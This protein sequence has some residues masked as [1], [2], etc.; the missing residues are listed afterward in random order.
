MQSKGNA[1][2]CMAAKFIL[3]TSL[4]IIAAAAVNTTRAQP[5][6][7]PEIAT[8]QSTTLTFLF[9]RGTAAIL[10]FDSD[11]V[12]DTENDDITVRFVFTIPDASTQDYDDRMETTATG[13]LL[14]VTQNGHD[15]EFKA[16][17]GVSPSDFQEVYEARHSHDVEVKMYA[18][19]GVADSQPLSFTIRTSYDASA[20]FHSPAEYQSAQRWTLLEI[21]IYEG[22]TAEAE[23]NDILLGDY[24]AEANPLAGQP[25]RLDL[26]NALQVPWTAVTSTSMSWKLGTPDGTTVPHVKCRD[27]ARL[28]THEWPEAGAKD[29]TDF[30]M[31]PATSATK[32]SHTGVRF[33]TQ[34]DHENPA[35]EDED[36]LYEVRMFNT[37]TVRDVDGPN[38]STGCTGSAV[39]L[40]VRVKDVGPPA[41]PTGVTLELNAAKAIAVSWNSPAPNEFIQDGKRVAFPH[42]S[43][44]VSG[45]KVSYSPDGLTQNSNP[46]PNPATLLPATTGIE[47]L[48]GTPGTTYTFTMVLVNSEGNSEEVVKSITIPGKPDAPDPVTLEPDG[49]NAIDIS[50][51]EPNDQGAAITGYKIQYLKPDSTEW[52]DWPHTG[53]NATAR[54]TGLKPNSTYHV[55][56]KAVN[57]EG[58][59]AWSPDKET[60]TSGITVSLSADESTVVK[61][62]TD[63]TV[64]VTLDEAVEITAS[65]KYEWT[66]GFGT[67]ETVQTDSGSQMSWT[68]QSAVDSD[69]TATADTGTLTV[70]VEDSD[71]YITGTSDSVTI[72]LAIGNRAPVIRAPASTT[73]HHLFP[74]GTKAKL[75][76]AGTPATDRNG[77][78]ISYSFTFAR[79]GET[80][81]LSPADT[82]LSIERDGDDF[83]ISALG[84]ATPAQYAALHGAKYTAVTLDGKLEAS[85][86]KGRSSSMDFTLTLHHDASA[87]FGTPAAYQSHQRWAVSTEYTT[88]EGAGAAA[89]IEIPWTSVAAGARTWSAGLPT[90]TSVNCEDKAGARLASQNWPAA[91]TTDSALVDAESAED[92][93]SGKLTLSFKTA[94]DYESPGDD[95]ADNVHHIR[96][97]SLHDLH[98]LGQEG[99]DMGCDGS[100]VDIT[101]K[102]KDVGA[103]VAPADLAGEFNTDGDEISISWTTSTGFTEGEATTAFPHT[104]F[105]VAKYQYQYR[106]GSAQDWSIIEET[107]GTSV[108]ITGLDQD[109]YM[110]RVNAV[111]SEGTSAWSELTV[112]T[113]ENQPPVLA[114]LPETTLWLRFPNGSAGVLSFT[115]PPAV[116]PEEDP[117]TYRFDMTL[118]EQTGRHAL[119]DGLLQ[120][121]KTDNNFSFTPMENISPA[122][123]AEVY[124]EHQEDIEV[125][126]SIHALDGDLESEPETFTIK[127]FYDASAYFDDPAEVETGNRYKIPEAITTYEGPGATGGLSPLDWTA[128][129]SGTRTWGKGNPATP[130]ACR[131]N[132]N[133]STSHTWPAEGK[134]DSAL[135][136]T[137]IAKTTGRSG[138]IALR[139]LSDPDYEQPG[140]GDEDNIHLVRY[141]NIHDLHNPT[142]DSKVPSCSGSAIDIR[143]EVK[144]VG[145]PAPV[146]L[147][148]AF[149]ENDRTKVDISWTAPTGFLE[150]DTLVAF[151]H[152]S[153]NPTGYEYRYRAEDTPPWTTVTGVT[154]TSATISGLTEAS[155]NVQ[156]RGKNTEGTSPWPTSNITV[157]LEPR[158]PDKPDKPTVTS[159]THNQIT[160][161]WEAPADNLSALTGYNVEIRR[162]GQS[163]WNELSHS[164]N[165]DDGHGHKPTGQQELPTAG[166]SG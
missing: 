135:M 28:H 159:K 37:N 1:R 45:R 60:T 68:L 148:G 75:D 125:N 119:A 23:L 163:T 49:R 88:Y 42:T 110:L 14:V 158:K 140:D 77:D 58:E 108:T 2:W 94:P 76:F 130:V 44:N 127:L 61:G 107:T 144:D 121:E 29:S 120:V 165:W 4:L 25:P 160:I 129:Q 131:N 30:L 103:P 7:P 24:N 101:L 26:T 126:L 86:R 69:E 51:T 65:L 85:D 122:E 33:K 32:A 62:G 153:F 115:G 133:A 15:Y 118:P 128:H 67:D 164:G 82:L 59:S 111:N 16:K 145:T 41:P 11:P 19:D 79:D 90:A 10:D 102:V 93:A 38:Q 63:A 141:H 81:A 17:T 9:P 123:F 6:A 84:T 166:P 134:T 87:Q 100:A 92:A 104:S 95:G 106:W 109:G 12:T 47:N 22:P 70:S 66:G 56:V 150:D 136:A 57:A 40:K 105:N 152:T 43:F 8:P 96:L 142:E 132:R 155:Y 97:V 18:N 72:P 48:V 116:D 157:T 71:D 64:T 113:L 74:R 91:G 78:S 54:L 114:D 21:A 143:I 98:D 73:L 162:K 35:D 5:N 137:P 149:Q 146:T 139:F 55:Q 80:E 89:G 53:T 31:E 154:A 156:A 83:L 117:M 13:A 50:W 151:P 36:N 138:Q 147:T 52:S 34:P 124:G 161:G 3:V 112:G 20:Q 99:K 27:A 39:D 46:F